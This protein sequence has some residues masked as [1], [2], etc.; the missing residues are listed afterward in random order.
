MRAEL[1]LP[2]P[3]SPA[4]T[5]VIVLPFLKY[6]ITS[7]WLSLMP[8]ISSRNF[9][10]HAINSFLILDV[11]ISLACPFIAE[12]I[13]TLLLGYKIH[14]QQEYSAII[15]DFAAALQATIT[16]KLHIPIKY[17]IIA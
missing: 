15:K 12:A 8:L 3:L 9:G 13:T 11:T 17:R 10:D 16:I 6:T 2:R 14:L 1:L 4:V 7:F 5:T